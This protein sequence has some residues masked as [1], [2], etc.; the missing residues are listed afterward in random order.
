[1]R[2]SYSQWIFGAALLMVSTAA[3]R[4]ATAQ[5]QPPAPPAVH[6][7]PP[8]PAD[9]GQ[10]RHTP[11]DTR[12]MQGMIAHHAQAVVMTRMV[13]THTDNAGLRLLA[14]RIDLS[15]QDEMATMRRWLRDRGEPV[16]PADTGH[17]AHHAPGMHHE[18][19]GHG[20]MP[21]MLTPEELA[22]LDAARGVEFDALFLELMIRHHQGALVMVEQLL[23]TPGAGQEPETFNFAS[24]VDADQRAEIARMQ[25]MLAAISPI[26]RP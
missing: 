13:P 1:M 20:A 14:Q 15:Q 4:A 16:P 24:E 22:R 10:R 25:G 8:P 26:A 2:S 18:P 7:H 19:P 3:C 12:F 5:T 17:A 11:A 23:A 21:G 6:A 9:T